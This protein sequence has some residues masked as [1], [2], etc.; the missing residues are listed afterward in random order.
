MKVLINGLLILIIAAFLLASRGSDDQISKLQA[1]VYLRKG[2]THLLQ[3]ALDEQSAEIEQLK[4][5]LENLQ[6]DVDDLEQQL[7]RIQ[8]A[9]GDR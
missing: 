3:S 9:L 2:E 4:D 8:L 1:E 6:G 5:D 7:V